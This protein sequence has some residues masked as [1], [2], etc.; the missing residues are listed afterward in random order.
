MAQFKYSLV[1]RCLVE[2]T[3]AALVEYLTPILF[4]TASRPGVD[5][6]KPDGGLIHESAIALA[7]FQKLLMHPELN[8]HQY[9]I[10]WEHQL[11]NAG[12][13]NPPRADLY[14]SPAH[15]AGG[16]KTWIE[17]GDLTKGK[18]VSDAN[19]LLRHRPNDSL[20]FLGLDL[21]PPDSRKSRVQMQRRMESA[22]KYRLDVG[23]LASCASACRLI[24]LPLPPLE[25]PPRVGFGVLKVRG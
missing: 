25:S 8:D 10:R 17:I 13:R 14:L 12:G 4:L 23:S 1:P 22:A 5:Q 19:K 7:V 11:T 20:F 21:N 9:E 16:V 15:G 3:E 18:I 24:T 2:A 6:H